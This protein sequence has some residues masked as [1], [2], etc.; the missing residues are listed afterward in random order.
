MNNIPV[1]H[2]LKTAKAVKLLAYAIALIGTVASYG[3][4]VALLLTHQVGGFSYVIPSTVDLLAI[5]AALALQLHGLDR[6]TRWIAG[7]ILT[8]A[9]AVSVAAN[10]TGGHNTI[11][12]IAHAWPVIAYL[13]GEL[14]AN[15]VRAYAARLMAAQS[16]SAPRPP[17]AVAVQ[18]APTTPVVVPDAAPVSP[19]MPPVTAPTV[20][21]VTRAVEESPEA[22]AY[23]EAWTAERAMRRESRIRALNPAAV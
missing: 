3:T 13:F 23:R 2:V 14:L 15:R 11:A 10:I 16:H 5:C 4:Q 8:V 20:A 6:T 1:E 21:T 7:T 19:G 9:V 22:I 17:A 18:P 12:K